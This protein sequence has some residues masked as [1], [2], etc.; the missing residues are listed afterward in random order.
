MPRKTILTVAEPALRDRLSAL[1]RLSCQLGG[2][3]HIRRLNRE[4]GVKCLVS[5]D[6]TARLDRDD[7]QVAGVQVAGADRAKT[8]SRGTNAS[9]AQRGDSTDEGHRSAA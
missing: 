7:Q 5:R 8:I 3:D 2:G 4:C 1:A 9:A 6:L